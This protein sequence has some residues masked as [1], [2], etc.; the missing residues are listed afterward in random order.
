MLRPTL[1][2]VLLTASLTSCG[3]G[4]GEASCI[5]AVEVDGVRYYGGDTPDGDVPTTGEV[6]DGVSPACNDTGGRLD[7]PDEDVEVQVIE[8]V[9]VGTA[10]LY[11]GMVHLR[12]GARLP[13]SAGA[14]DLSYSCS[15]AGKV[16]LEGSWETVSEP[17][18]PH[19]DGVLDP[20]YEVGIRV[21]RGGPRRLADHLVEVQV[22][23]E[24]DPVLARDDLPLLGAVDLTATVHCLEGGFVAASL[25]VVR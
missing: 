14:W 6:V 24:T 20:P 13:A 16:R 9:P 2:A 1:L 11:A 17:Y 3:A 12:E 5:A 22:T 21:D 7:E 10:V 23:D 15:T 18:A 8:G 25:E 4:A 19:F